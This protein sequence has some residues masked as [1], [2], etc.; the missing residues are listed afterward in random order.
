MTL[1]LV[2]EQI[3][4]IACEYA[5]V[6]VYADSIENESFMEIAITDDKKIEFT[7]YSYNEQVKLS[8]ANW[9]EIMQRGRELY[10]NQTEEEF[11]N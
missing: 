5:Y 7:I 2:F 10:F 1:S 11:H 4:D 6:C 3:S 9:T 8:Y